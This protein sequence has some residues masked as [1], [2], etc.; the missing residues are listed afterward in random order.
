M[1]RINAHQYF[2]E[3]Y[4][5]KTVPPDKVLD[6]FLCDYS[7]CVNPEHLML[8]DPSENSVRGVDKQHGRGAFQ[9]SDPPPTDH[10]P[11]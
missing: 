2:W 3:V 1:K 4:T 7:L 9:E 11:F 8:A 10:V 6:H 5:G